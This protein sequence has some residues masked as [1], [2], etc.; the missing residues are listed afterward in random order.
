MKNYHGAMTHEPSK[1]IDVGVHVWAVRY[2][3]F[4]SV[5]CDWQCYMC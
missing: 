2:A 3:H 1:Q 4:G 5:S